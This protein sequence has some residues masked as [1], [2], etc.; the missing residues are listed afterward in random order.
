MLQQVSIDHNL[1]R[2]T[3]LVGSQSNA[4]KE[5]ETG[6]PSMVMATIGCMVSLCLRLQMPTWAS[7]A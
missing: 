4:M 3:I 1:Y 7:G 6:V 5:A 2:E